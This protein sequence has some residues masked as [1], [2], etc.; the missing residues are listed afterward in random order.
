[1]VKKVYLEYIYI[2]FDLVDCYEH[3]NAPEIFQPVWNP[4]RR[5]SAVA[6][7]DPLPLDDACPYH[8]P[9]FVILVHG[10]SR[11][12]IATIRTSLRNFLHNHHRNACRQSDN[13]V[14][15]T[16]A[17]SRADDQHPGV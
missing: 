17:N 9:R 13:P 11:F 16:E 8:N 10:R 3:G 6:L 15:E 2:R 14:L 7:V 1:M 4:L 12:S 5:E